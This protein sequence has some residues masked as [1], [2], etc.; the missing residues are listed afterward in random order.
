MVGTCRYGSCTTL[1]RTTSNPYTSNDVFTVRV[2]SAGTVEWLVNGVVTNTV[3][4]QG[5][6]Y[7]LYVNVEIHGSTVYDIVWV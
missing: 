4:G 2:P 7:P 5:I 1:A 3:T 6:A